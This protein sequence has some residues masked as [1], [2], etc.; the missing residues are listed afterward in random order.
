MATLP[1]NQYFKELLFHI[2]IGGPLRSV[3]SSSGNLQL[4]SQVT[5][6]CDPIAGI[7]KMW[8]FDPNSP[9]LQENGQSFHSSLLSQTRI[10]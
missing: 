2:I 10:L 7:F 9:Q 6:L 8:M 5:S 3:P 4:D 1:L